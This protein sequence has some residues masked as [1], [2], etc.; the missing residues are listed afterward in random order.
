MV[1]GW[2]STL[3]VDL[4]S[5][6][7]PTL[8]MLVPRGAQRGTEVEFTARGERLGDVEEA[9]LWRPGVVVDGLMPAEDGKSVKLRMTMAP[10]CPLGE[11]YVRLR[12][13]SGLSEVRT[14]WIGQFPTVDEKEPNTDF[15]AAQ[16]V[17]MNVTVEGVAENE[18]VDYYAVDLKQGD[19]LTVEVEGLRLSG[20]FWDPY[21]AIL[22]KNRFE[23]AGADDT[24][25]LAQDTFAQIIAP[26]DGTYTVEVRD[27]SYVG[28]GRCRYRL[29]IGHQPRP[30]AVYPAGGRTGTT[31]DVTLLGDISGTTIQSVTLPPK[32]ES[33]WGVFAEADGLSAASPNWLRVSDFDNVLE[34]EPN[35]DFGQ[36]TPA[37]G[38]LPLAF[39]GIIEKPGDVDRFRFEA[40]KDEAFTFIAHAK[41]IRSPL[42]PVIQIFKASDQAHLA[43]NDDAIGVDSKIDFKAP[44]DGEYV[45]VVFDHLRGGGADFVY[46][47][48][49]APATPSLTLSI[50][51]FARNDYQ[52]RQMM[53]VPRG[54]RVAAIVNANRVN[55]GGDLAFEVD[56][57]PP[58]VT[59]TAEVM[60]Q[61]SGGGYPVVFTAAPDAP[62]GGAMVDLGARP[63]DDH[64]KHLRGGFI[65]QLDL[66]MGEPNNTAYY[67]S[68]IEKLAVAVVEEVPFTLEVE[69]PVVPLVHHG[70]LNLR[71][72]ARRQDGFK[73]P[74]TVRRMFLPPNMGAQP[75]IT[76][77]EGESEAVYSLNAN[78]NAELRTWH[79]AFIGESD[80]GQGTILASSG[81]V[82]VRVAAPYLAMKLE[83]A[84]IEQGQAGEVVAK[85]EQAHAFEGKARVV[86]EGLPA[87]AQ[88]AAVEISKDDTE[89]HFAVTTTADTPVG[90]HKQLF[91]S[92]EVPE[93][94][95]FVLHTAGQGGT[96]RVDAPPPAP[97]ADIAAADPATPAPAP[98]PPPVAEKPLSRLEKLRLEA[99][100]AAGR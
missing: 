34:V 43:S 7:D 63:T 95:A 55:F 21:V 69:T 83:M 82:S 39:N 24:A 74:I 6:A 11:H 67:T 23:L 18:D 57:L 79:L 88:A 38:G 50:P 9:M 93:A 26:A 94:G 51:Q 46:R 16:R 78:G 87:H 77:P 99:K 75:T 89:I 73:A 2:L 84:A 20:A 45:L 86:L 30:S 10:D 58:G 65:H 17:P 71:V 100:Q 22:D 41:S 96:L 47:V 56:G 37:P 13:R 98:A 66:M 53:P 36:A 92:I 28:N 59:M 49:A 80:A 52:S 72:I 3:A 54:N 32:E 35:D 61:S 15:E 31:M 90:K 85:I 76:I 27:S 14:F 44:E 19:R 1:A 91:A 70:T 12:A 5:A 60:P 81:L 25:L 62:L 4:V 29:H 68:V 8:R 97:A 42:D 33:K 40:K 48:E 64:L